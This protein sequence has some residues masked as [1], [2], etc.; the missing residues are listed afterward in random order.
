MKKGSGKTH[1][2][3]GPNPHRK[4]GTAS[5]SNEHVPTTATAANQSDGLMVKAIDEIF[6]HVEGSDNPES[7]K[8]SINV[9]TSHL[10]IKATQCIR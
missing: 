1:T 2:M 3:L 9:R 4:A 6:R 10:H 7:F 8:V 5:T